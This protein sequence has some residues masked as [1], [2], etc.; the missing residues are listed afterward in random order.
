VNAYDPVLFDL[1]GTVID[2]VGLIR[3]SHRHAVTTVLGEDLPDARLVANVGRPLID[4]MRAF[5]E[6]RAEELLRVYR[7]WNHANTAALLRPFPGI[8]ALLDALA[9]DGRTLGIVTSKSA[10]T[11]ELAWDVVPL[12]ERFAVVVTA[13][14][15]PRH[16]PHPD[17]VLAALDALGHDAAGACYVGDSPFDLESGAA[18]GVAAIGVTWGFFGRAA[19]EASGP[20]AV[21]DTPEELARVL[22]VALAPATRGAGGGPPDPAADGGR[23]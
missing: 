14:D 1:D 19:L 3:E 20:A 17:P 15:T 9:A 10:P 11:V 18:A 13:E 22:G 16:K 12:R 8:D 4:Q 2:S 7:A 23:P 6:E 5:S 21:V